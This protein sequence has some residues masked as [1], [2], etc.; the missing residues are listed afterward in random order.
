MARAPKSRPDVLPVFSD[1]HVQA[2]TAKVS[3]G[4]MAH[5]RAEAQALG[6]TEVGFNGDFYHVRG[7][8]PVTL[9][10]AVVDELN[11]WWDAGITLVA[12][13]GNH[14]Q[15]DVAGRHA[16]EALRTHPA[17]RLYDIPTLDHWGLWIPYRHDLDE[18][19]TALKE[20]QG[21]TKRVFWHGSVIGAKMNDHI[22]ADR[23]LSPE[24]FA[25]YELA[26]LGH[27][28]LRQSYGVAHYV[29]SPWE[30][31][32]D[33]AGQPK[34]YAVVEGSQIRYVDRV[35]G[36]RHLKIEVD[37][38]AAAKSAIASAQPGDIVR[39]VAPEGEVAKVSKALA[40]RSLEVSVSPARAEVS[41]SRALP[42]GPMSLHD[43][44]R[45]F[46][47]ERAG[48]LPKDQLLKAFEEI[49]Q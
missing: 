25:G 47:D 26:V 43:H 37:S 21:Q 20:Y 8:L 44:A 45:R 41:S 49:A 31:R 10:N 13:P 4:V 34:G 2:S 12:I 38:A 5:M 28:H 32:S 7:L 40:G 35:W 14:D 22:R 36:P 1:L 48:D 42:S 27:F 46:V 30:T 17:V 24:D 11:R 6:V 3:L 15:V 9:Q 33:E 39:V 18:V 29:G 19:R 23:G 16:L